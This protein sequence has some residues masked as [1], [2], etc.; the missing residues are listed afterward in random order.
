VDGICHVSQSIR[1]FHAHH[2]GQPCHYSGDTLEIGHNVTVI[3]ALP[4]YNQAAPCGIS[5]SFDGGIVLHPYSQLVAS[6]IHLRSSNGSISIMKGA[7][8]DADGLGTCVAGFDPRSLG[9]DK[10]GAGHGGYGGSCTPTTT[11]ERGAAAYGDATD[12]LR[13]D[14]RGSSQLEASRLFP[15]QERRQRGSTAGGTHTR[16]RRCRVCP[17]AERRA[18]CVRAAVK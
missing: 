5:L 7:V 12:P 6:L 3:C 1:F 9:S 11:L 13:R 2:N 16:A 10:M 14:L 17:P 15:S 8:L 18:V 4:F